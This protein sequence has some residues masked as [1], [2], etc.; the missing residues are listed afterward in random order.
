[1]HRERF[2]F[3]LCRTFFQVMRTF[4]IIFLYLR[5]MLEENLTF[6]SVAVRLVVTTEN[7]E[8]S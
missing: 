6:L 3:L 4:D 1:M 8:A 5:S 2:F 7:F